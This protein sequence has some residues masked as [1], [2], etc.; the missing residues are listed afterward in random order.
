MWVVCLIECEEWS[1]SEM[2][3]DHLSLT[4]AETNTS[5]KQFLFGVIWICSKLCLA[6]VILKL[7][8]SVCVFCA[9]SAAGAQNK[10]EKVIK[11]GHEFCCM[12]QTTHYLLTLHSYWMYVP[13]EF[14]CLFSDLFHWL[15]LL[16]SLA[17]LLLPSS[18]CLYLCTSPDQPQ[19]PQATR[20]HITF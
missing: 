15:H 2:F 18:L 16:W 7:L 19:C 9:M 1:W 20:C 14:T 3:T 6:L 4:A 13:F 10:K 12:A 17:L 8:T 11:G 5:S